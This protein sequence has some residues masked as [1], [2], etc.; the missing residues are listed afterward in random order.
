MP[1]ETLSDELIALGESM[2]SI[3]AIG[4]SPPNEEPQSSLVP[5]SP[6]AVPNG[7]STNDTSAHPTQSSDPAGPVLKDDNTDLQSKPPNDDDILKE[8]KEEEEVCVLVP[9]YLKPY[10][11]APV[12]WD[13]ETKVQTPVLLQ[14][15]LCPY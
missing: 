15:M 6:P 10:T 9:D 13:A 5:T 12:E 7:A 3:S 11:V 4:G 2:L 1:D 8:E 14:G